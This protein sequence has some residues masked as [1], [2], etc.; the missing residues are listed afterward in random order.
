[1]TCK[2][3]QNIAERLAN[4]HSENITLREIR[5]AL[6]TLANFYEDVRFEREQTKL[7]RKQKNGRLVNQKNVR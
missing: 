5:M 3:A 6:V 4:F 1:M 2:E 7:K